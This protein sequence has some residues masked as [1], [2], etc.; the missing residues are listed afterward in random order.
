MGKLGTIPVWLRVAL[1][2]LLLP[3]TCFCFGSRSGFDEDAPKRPVVAICLDDELVV[4]SS[5]AV[6]GG[7]GMDGDGKSSSCV[8]VLSCGMRILSDK[9]ELIS[10]SSVIR[11]HDSLRTWPATRRYGVYVRVKIV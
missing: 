11:L 2:F 3:L 6:Y 5:W 7:L 1:A 10:T 9:S 8:A 4:E